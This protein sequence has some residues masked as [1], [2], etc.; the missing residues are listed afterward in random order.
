M[1]SDVSAPPLEKGQYA[2]YKHRRGFRMMLLET[3]TGFAMFHISEKLLGRPKVVFT[4][5]FIEI[6]NKSV[7]RDSAVGP[8]D[9]LREFILRFY[10][11]T[12]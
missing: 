9:D 1:A 12:T 10:T 7:A 11:K 4:V 2:Y 6:H 3:L 5:G 8:G